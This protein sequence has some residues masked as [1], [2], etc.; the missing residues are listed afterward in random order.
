MRAGEDTAAAGGQLVVLTARWLLILFGLSI[1]L[2]SPM[3]A[4]LDKVRVSLFVLLGLA[5]G[6]FF[7]NAR[8]LSR[9]R[10]PD[11][12][13][14]ATSLADIGVISMLT[15]VY[16]GLSAP[17]FV[18]Y[19]PAVIALALAFPL[20]LSSGLIAVLLG[21]YTVI[22]VPDISGAAGAQT[23][24]VRL[25]ALAGAATVAAVFRGV[26]ADRRRATGE[27]L[28]PEDRPLPELAV[29]EAAMGHNAQEVPA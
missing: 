16:G 2:W 9:S 20:E 19:F 24:G 22:C 7:L 17:V 11:G 6:N 5:I 18:F 29:Q 12:V 14:V 23:L 3:Q 8:V 15:A 21:L 28:L 10:L 26:E 1:T 13:A 25:I 4:D 27:T